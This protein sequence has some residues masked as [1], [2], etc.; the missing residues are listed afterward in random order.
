MTDPHP[1]QLYRTVPPAGPSTFGRRTEGRR[2][3]LPRYAPHEGAVYEVVYT[4]RAATTPADVDPEGELSAEELDR[5]LA[6]GPALPLRADRTTWWATR[7]AAEA[8]AKR[9]LD[10]A[11]PRLNEEGAGRPVVEAQVRRD[12]SSVWWASHDET[13]LWRVEAIVREFR[14]VV[15]REGGVVA[16][17]RRAAPNDDGTVASLTVGAAD[18]TYSLTTRIRLDAVVRAGSDGQRSAEERAAE[19]RA[20]ERACARAAELG[21]EVAAAVAA[22]LTRGAV[23]A[24]PTGEE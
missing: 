16:V 24:Y 5:R 18:G 8:E 21:D 1:E 23:S 6:E 10:E 20:I 2:F 22:A 17:L 12:A 15:E 3:G 11:D 14:E 9:L 13:A 19:P 7:E 4:D